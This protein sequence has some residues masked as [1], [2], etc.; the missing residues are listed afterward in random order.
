MINE[1]DYRPYP[2]PEKP[3]V[4]HQTWQDLLFMH[5]R[6]PFEE[7]RRVVPGV[8][9]LDT[10]DGS[11]WVGVVPFRVSGAR[12]RFLPALPGVS[13]FPELNLRTYVTVKGKPGVFFFSLDAASPIAVRLARLIFRLPYFDAKM[14][15]Q[16][17][18]EGVQYTSRRIQLEGRPPEFRARYRPVG[19]VFIAGRD[20]LEYFLTAR[21]C[22]YV[23]NQANGS[24][25]RCEIHH[26]PWPLQPAQAELTLNTLTHAHGI[27][28]RNQPPH[29]L[30][31]RRLDVKVWPL[32]PVV[33]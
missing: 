14:T 12:P 15:C 31:A 11:A 9:P 18:G 27:R 16:S 19:P 13:N 28:L 7:L 21:Y 22:L 24:I 33:D 10:F 32:A 2:P 23:V 25:A 30:F 5:W 17:N 29:L 26:A 3:F 20:T 8:L 1:I 4:M 6:V